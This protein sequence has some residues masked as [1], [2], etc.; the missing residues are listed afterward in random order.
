[1]VKVAFRVCQPVN[2]VDAQPVNDAAVHQFEDQP[3][4]IIKDGFIFNAYPHQTGYLEKAAIGERMG[5][6]TPAGE[7]PGLR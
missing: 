5:R 4:R 7:S 3:V 2:V 6:V 1:M